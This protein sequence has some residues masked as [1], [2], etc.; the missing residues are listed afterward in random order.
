M[1]KHSDE[2]P[3]IGFGTYLISDSEAASIVS[4]AIDI[5]YRHIDTA[6]G[7]GNE[8]GIGE[9]LKNSLRKLSLTRE[10]IFITSKLFPGNPA[11]GREAKNYANCISACD[12]SLSRLGLNFLDCYL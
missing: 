8:R 10:D 5:G 2:M 12:N 6:E 9:A 4:T 3:Q 11:W 1:K 7:Y